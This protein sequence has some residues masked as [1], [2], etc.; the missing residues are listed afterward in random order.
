LA[1]QPE[2]TLHKICDF[3][4]EPFDEQML[5]MS[6]AAKF[7]DEGSNSSYTSRE[8]GA[9][10]TDS[11]GRYRE[12]LSNSDIAFIQSFT[13]SHMARFGYEPDALDWSAT[14]RARLMVGDLP[15]ETGRLLAWRIRESVRNRRGR[16]LPAYRLVP[17]DQRS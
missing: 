2:P 3:I 14:P 13:R 9:I 16:P 8:P 17:G 7:R 4:G 6:G 11:I 15:L 1:A 12:V 10:S 5:S